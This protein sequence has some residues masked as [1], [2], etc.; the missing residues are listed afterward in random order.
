NYET[1]ELEE[2]YQTYTPALP[3]YADGLNSYYYQQF[4]EVGDF[5]SPHYT[6]TIKINLTATDEIPQILDWNRKLDYLFTNNDSG[7]IVNSH[8]THQATRELSDHCP[9]S[10]KLEW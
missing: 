6:H 10:V 5:F 4:E 1:T 3:L 7:W 9:I 2:L 8:Q